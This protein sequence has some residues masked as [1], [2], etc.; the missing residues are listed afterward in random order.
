MIEKKSSSIACFLTIPFSYPF[1]AYRKP[2]LRL[3]RETQ[4]VR[5]KPLTCEKKTV[6]L[7]TTCEKKTV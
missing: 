5:K 4:P 2:L 6:W 1:M 7:A 3:D